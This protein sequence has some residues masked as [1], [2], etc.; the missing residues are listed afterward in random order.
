MRNEV[1]LKYANLQ[2]NDLFDPKK[3]EIYFLQLGN[4]IEKH[5]NQCFKNI[6]KILKVFHFFIRPATF[7]VEYF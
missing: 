4:L 2:Y 7:S 5:W 1:R 6:F 3:C